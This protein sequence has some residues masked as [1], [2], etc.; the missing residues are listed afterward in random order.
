MVL[1]SAKAAEDAAKAQSV[2]I[3]SVDF[4]K[5]YIR[6]HP[7]IGV[8]WLWVWWSPMNSLDSA[9]LDNRQR[10]TCEGYKRIQL[11][12]RPC[13]AR[14]SMSVRISRSFRHFLIIGTCVQDGDP[15][16]LRRRSV[17]RAWLF[18]CRFALQ[19]PAVSTILLFR[20]QSNTTGCICIPTW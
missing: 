5:A 19:D 20:A 18:P 16:S 9:W 10:T 8:L 17:M 15:F 12:K 7:F 1:G 3:K 13:F 2:A 14:F 6:K 11:L 4:L